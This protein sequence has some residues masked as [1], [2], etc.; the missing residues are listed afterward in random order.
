[1]RLGIVIAAMIVFTLCG[2]KVNAEDSGWIKPPKDHEGI[3]VG[4]FK[5][6]VRRAFYKSDGL[7]SG[8][9]RCIAIGS[10]NAPYTGTAEGLARY[11]DG[12]WSVVS[13]TEGKAILAL[14]AMPDGVAAAVADGVLRVADEGAAPMAGFSAGTISTL[15]WSDTLLAGSDQGLFRLDGDVFVAVDALN[16]VLGTRCDVRQVAVGPEGRLAVAAWSGLF[17]READGVWQRPVPEEKGRR[18]A[19]Q[20][21]RGAAFDARGRL[22][23]ASPQGVACYDGEWHLFTGCE[24]LPYD[25]FTTVAAGDGGI[26]FGTRIGAVSFAANRW[27]YRQGRRWLPND[28]V[29]GIAVS[30]DGNAWFATARGV[31]LIE[32]RDM[33]F[34]KKAKFFEDEID[35]HH[36]RT[37]LGYVDSVGLAK[38]GDTSE[39]QQRDSDNDGLWTSMYGA[40]E[41]FAYAATGSAEA[42]ARAKAA[43]EALRFLGQVTQG[44][45]HP[46]P[47]GFVARTILPTSGPDPN[48]GRIEGDREQKEKNDAYWKVYEPRWPKSEDGQWYWKSDTSSDELDGHYFFYATYYDL[49]ADTDDERARVREHVAALTDHLVDHN[50]NLVDWEGTPTRWAR[51]SPDEM[52][53]DPA[54]WMERGLNSLS[55]LSYLKVALHLTGD[56]KYHEAAQRLINEHGYAMNLM[57]PKAQNGPGSGNQS[58]DEMAFMSYYNLLKYEADPDLRGIYGFS[59]LNYWRIIEPELNPLFNFICAASITGDTFTDPW[60]T[61]DL[62]PTGSWLEESVDTLKRYPTDRFRWGYRNSHRKD[63]VSLP[64]YMREGGARGVGHRRNGKVLPIDERFVEH[65]NHDPWQLDSGGDGRELADGASFLLPYYM[66]LYHGFI[67]EE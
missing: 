51:Y 36:R 67:I 54:W 22:W 62:T 33:T 41:C 21:V 29:R 27:A 2:V 26:W 14:A 44:G 35:K 17:A 57:Y 61:T 18:W 23:C 47:K 8:D 53:H 50:F 15:A 60:G 40:G 1:M 55:I 43:F 38:P 30:A 56:A 34:A 3:R 58:D 4:A 7:P 46:A 12:A 25:D 45:E 16:T 48:V 24:G 65:W 32:R 42:K 6:E 37:P 39:W 63:I 64:P 10:D 11:A 5:A 20:D 52:N 13:G 28:D 66:G 9:V 59:L 31:G 49:V 19:L